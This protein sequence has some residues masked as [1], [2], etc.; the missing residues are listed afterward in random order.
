MTLQGK[1]SLG[2]LYVQV[3]ISVG[4]ITVAELLG[5]KKCICPASTGVTQPATTVLILVLCVSKQPLLNH[6][7]KV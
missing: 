2:F 5:P 3:C 1:F 6:K 4:H 7:E